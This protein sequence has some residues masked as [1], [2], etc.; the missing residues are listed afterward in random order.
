[1][2]SGFSA[3]L[4]LTKNRNNIL[5]AFSKMGFLFDEIIRIKVIGYV[6]N[7]SSRELLYLLNLIPI[8][9]KIRIFLDWNIFNPSFTRQMSR[10]FEVR[11]DII[12]CIALDDVSYVPSTS[13]SLGTKRGFS[14]F[15]KD[16]E[17]SWTQLLQIYI[18][19][20]NK[21]NFDSLSR[22]LLL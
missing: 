13:I 5:T 10:L 21:L 4:K 14:K 8:N 9:R 19:K 12:H 2:E 15:K 6:D 16:M 18:S 7:S 3:N 20:Q 1:M 22:D 17:K 11:N